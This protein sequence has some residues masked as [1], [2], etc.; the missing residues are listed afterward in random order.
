MFNKSEEPGE[1]E[2]VEV[3]GLGTEG[4]DRVSSAP[5]PKTKDKTSPE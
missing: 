5:A 3:Q 4:E 2:I 1:L